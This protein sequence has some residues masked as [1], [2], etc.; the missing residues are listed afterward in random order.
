VEKTVLVNMLTYAPV[1][2]RIR[3]PALH[4]WDIQLARVVRMAL[5]ATQTTCRQSLYARKSAGG[6]QMPSL[7]AEMVAAVARET[8]V[9]LNREELDSI[10]LRE[11]WKAAMQGK[12][13][14]VAEAVEFLA[15]YGLYI[16]DSQHRFTLHIL[17]E[18]RET[19]GR[20]QPATFTQPWDVNGGERGRSTSLISPLGRDVGGGKSG[21]I[22]KR[23]GPIH[24]CTGLR[25]NAGSIVGRGSGGAPG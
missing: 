5:R 17:C 7:V 4:Q 23:G 6:L 18:L 20:R 16:T 3:A 21:T 2:S 9:A 1:H 22:E 13:S 10:L 19:G 12:P 8:L 24:G 15:G 11:R 25:R 14:V